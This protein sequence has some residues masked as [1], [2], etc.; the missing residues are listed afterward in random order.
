MSPHTTKTKAQKKGRPRKGIEAG[1]AVADYPAVTLRIR[2]DTRAALRALAVVTK[3]PSW[4]LLH[5]AVGAAV[6]A[7]PAAQRDLVARLVAL[8]MEAKT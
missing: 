4:R 7:L 2:P 3:Q 1:E 6:K 8:D 5:D